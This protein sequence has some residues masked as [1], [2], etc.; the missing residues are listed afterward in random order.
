MIVSALIGLIPVILVILIAFFLNPI[1]GLIILSFV[2]IV[3]TLTLILTY[4]KKK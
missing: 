2:V 1:F 3:S 4:K